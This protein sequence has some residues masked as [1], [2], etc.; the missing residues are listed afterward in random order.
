M[1]V[2]GTGAWPGAACAAVLAGLT[3]FALPA[4]AQEQPASRAESVSPSPAL[5]DIL[6]ENGPG[7]LG[8]YEARGLVEPRAEAVLSSEIAGRIVKLPFDEGDA[9]EEGDLLVGFDCAAYKAQLAVAEAELEAARKK[10]ENSRKLARLNSIGDLEV[11]LAEVAVDQ[12][13]A[14]VRGKRLVVERCRL[15]APYDGKVVARPVNRYESVGQDQELLSVIAL[16][17]PEVRLIVPSRWVA[18]LAPGA[19]FELKVDETGAVYP[20]VVERVGARI[21][22]VS[23]TVQVI[24]RFA[25]ETPDLIPG[26]SGTARFRPDEQG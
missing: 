21:D 10:L 23:Q 18:W 2:R 14:T 3:L 25:A 19:G 9:F 6:R 1:T 16:G 13:E 7:P 17:A 22:P 20:G 26:M 5:R 8:R 24:G 11:G 15:T 12:A 4:P